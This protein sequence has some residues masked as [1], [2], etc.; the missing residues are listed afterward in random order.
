M[1][2]FMI[3][4]MLLLLTGCV[5]RIPINYDT[6]ECMCISY[7]THEEGSERVLLQPTMSYYYVDGV[8]S[9]AQS[10]GFDYDITDEGVVVVSTVNSKSQGFVVNLQ[11]ELL[12]LSVE[13][14]YEYVQGILLKP[15]FFPGHYMY[16]SEEYNVSLSSYKDG[17]INYKIYILQGDLEGYIIKVVAHEGLEYSLMDYTLQEGLPEPLYNNL[18]YMEH[19]DDVTLVGRNHYSDITISLDTLEFL[20]EKGTSSY[21]YMFLTNQVC[22]KIGEEY[23]CDE[24]S[25]IYKNNSNPDKGKDYK[26]DFYD[27]YSK[28]FFYELHNVIQKYYEL[29]HDHDFDE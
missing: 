9:Y 28:S 14:V 17:N 3:L 5:K 13:L 21:K 16:S 4:F 22:K 2:K 24:E 1:K 6:P 18:E 7:G 26:F 25:P 27:E 10:M 19:T 20:I 29:V 23:Y 15:T 11:K 8:F 12:D